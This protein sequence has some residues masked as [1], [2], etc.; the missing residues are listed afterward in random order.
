MLVT[1]SK[2]A[3]LVTEGTLVADGGCSSSNT[4]TSSAATPPYNGA[5]PNSVGV[6]TTQPR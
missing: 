6:T 5:G 2:V 3:A 4:A 1:W